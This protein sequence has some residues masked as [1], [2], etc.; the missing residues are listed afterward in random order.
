M[1]EG[2]TDQD[3]RRR[4]AVLRAFMDEHGRLRVMPTRS[5]RLLV[6]L[7]RLAQL[8]EPGERYEEPEVDRRLRAAHADV[9]TLRRHLVDHGFLTRER[10]LYWRTGGSVDVAQS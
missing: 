4:E 6:V 8:F 10:G 9:A 7:D 2:T 1:D 5:S 3:A